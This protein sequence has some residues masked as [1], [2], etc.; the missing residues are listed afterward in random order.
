[1]KTDKKNKKQVSFTTMATPEWSVK[2][3]ITAA[4]KYGYSGID[5]RAADYKGEVNI[6]TSDSE[7]TNIRNILDSEKVELAGLLCYNKVGG[8]EKD[9]WKEMEDS[10]VLHMELGYKL[11]SPS[12]RIFGGDPHNNLKFNNYIK[13][14]A[15][16]ISSALDRFKGINITIQNHKGSFTALECVELIELVNNNRFRMVFSPDHSFM[17]GEDMEKVYKAVMPYTFQLY[18]SD[19]I[20]IKNNKYKSI[21][22]GKGEVPIKKAYG[23]IACKN[24]NG[25]VTFKW[26]KIWQN[27]LEEPEIAL[28]YFINNL[29]E[30]LG[31]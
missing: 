1:M 14:I 19:V 24:F 3:A 30:I 26:E 7:I 10:I 27:Y 20:R 12:I 28:P 16:T 11:G 18:I 6:H 2:K 15:D 29:K 22:P 5:L 4:A 9:S 21:L 13:Y 8:I 31:N 25:Y 23:A 17:V